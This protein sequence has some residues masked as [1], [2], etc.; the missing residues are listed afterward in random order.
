MMDVRPGRRMRIPLN[1]RAPLV[2]LDI[3]GR[4]GLPWAIE[5]LVLNFAGGGSRRMR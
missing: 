1:L 4:D 3:V 5:E 2:W